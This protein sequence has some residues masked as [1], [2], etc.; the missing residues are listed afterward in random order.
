MEFR[1]QFRG[2]SRTDYL[3]EIWLDYRISS[4]LLKLRFQMLWAL[5]FRIPCVQ[6]PKKP[7]LTR[8]DFIGELPQC[9]ILGQL[10]LRAGVAVA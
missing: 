1:A 4:V 7:L 8:G 6:G 9:R 5:G 3:N 2:R 10:V